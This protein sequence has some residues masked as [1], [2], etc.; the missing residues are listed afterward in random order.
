MTDQVTVTMPDGTQTTRSEPLIPAR[1]STKVGV[2][3]VVAIV[4]IVQAIQELH[5]ANPSLESFIHSSLFVQIV[6]LAGAY[7]VARFTKSPIAAQ[8][9]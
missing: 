5:F 3:G 2:T 4:P 9:L 7:L 6:T 1:T 8:A